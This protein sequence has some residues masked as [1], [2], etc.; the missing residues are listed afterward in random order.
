MRVYRIKHPGMEVDFIDGETSQQVLGLLR[1]LES[2]FVEAAVALNLFKSE[3]KRRS[4][5]LRKDDVAKMADPK[6]TLKKW[7]AKL[8]KKNA[9]TEKY[10]VQFLN[11]GKNLFFGEESELIREKVDLELKQ[12]EWNA[13]IPPFR[14]QH[15]IIFI[16][17][18]A[19]ISA[20][21][22]FGKL[23]HVMCKEYAGLPAEVVNQKESFFNSFP[24]LKDVRDSIQH[25]EDRSR[26]LDR[27]G[28]P[29]DVKLGVKGGINIP[30]K[31]LVLNQLNGN[32]FGTIINN[33]QYAEVEVSDQTML[34]VHQCLQG[35]IDSF[36]WKGP[37]RTEP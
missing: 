19:F 17:A 5:D 32:Q 10:R 13:G 14:Y 7:E 6:F 20:L 2:S 22:M 33:G 16:Y 24:Q 18:K 23:L 31:S 25:D 29:L 36:T 26:G 35:I 34:L 28:N 8:E 12:E 9:L 27:K 11:E 37:G 30:V 3:R 1:N 21:D 15:A 4:D